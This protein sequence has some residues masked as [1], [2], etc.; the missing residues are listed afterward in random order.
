MWVHT[1]FHHFLEISQIFSNR[2]IFNKENTF[3]VA[4]LH[5]RRMELAITLFEWLRNPGKGT[6]GEHTLDP[7]KYFGLRHSFR[8]L[9]SLIQWYIDY[10]L[11]KIF[12]HFWLV[13]IPQLIP[14][15]LPPLLKPIWKMQAIYHWLVN[16]NYIIIFIQSISL[17]LIG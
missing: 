1:G 11:L 3:Q 13:S 16:T 5:P 15:N 7:P 6:L 4:R 9:V 8:K 17:F 14:H 2:Y 12:C 10:Y